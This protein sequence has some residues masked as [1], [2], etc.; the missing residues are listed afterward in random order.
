VEEPLSDGWTESAQ[1]W[2]AS[3]GDDGDYG[4]KFVLD[5]PMLARVKRQDFKTALDVGCGEGR[6]CRMLQTA[7]ISTVGIDP[8]AALVERAR[9]LDP[10]GDYRIARAETLDVPSA[11]FDLVVSYLSLIDIADL[12]LAASKMSGALRPGGM[13]LIAN[14]TSFNTAGMPEG[15]NT[16]SDGQRRF[17]IDHYLEARPVWVSWHGIRVQN[18]YRPLSAYMTAF[19]E[20]GLELRH[21]DEPAPVWWRPRGRR[22]LSK[23]AVLRDH[24]VAKT[25]RHLTARSLAAKCRS[26]KARRKTC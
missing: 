8:T 10:T 16:D 25:E 17:C 2:L 20:C 5:A 19:L 14:L 23:S 4:R 18:W 12:A 9:Q 15:W 24:G 1:A 11:S 7:G 21:F 3:I 6:F 26:H 22:A 13:L